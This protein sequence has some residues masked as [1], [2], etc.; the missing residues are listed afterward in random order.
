MWS[1]WAIEQYGQIKEFDPNG[2]LLPVAIASD[3]AELCYEQ[4]A[5]PIYMVNKALPLDEKR[6]RI[7]WVL[8]RHSRC[9][10]A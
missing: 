6:K 10:E 9:G 4:T 5:D 1:D 7:Y 2:L 3:K 8:V